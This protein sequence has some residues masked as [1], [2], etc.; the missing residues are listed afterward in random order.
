[1]RRR[2][3]HWLGGI[4]LLSLW[5]CNDRALQAPPDVPSSEATVF[6]DQDFSNQLDVLFVV[7]DSSS[8]Q[9]VQA[10]LAANFPTFIHVLQELPTGLPD[11]HIGVTTSS[12]GAGAFTA[13]VP[14][15][16]TPD[17]GNLV[18]QPRARAGTPECAAN[19]ITGPL[20]FI[21][22]LGQD[23]QRNF[24]GDTSQVFGC[25]AQVGADGCGF[26]QT[27]AAARGALGD[28][29]MGLPAPEGNSQFLREDA[30]LA[31]IWITNEDDC[32]VPPDS[33]LFDAHDDALGPFSYRCT[34]WGILCGG[35]RPPLTDSGPLA[36]CAS[37]DALATTAPRKSLVPVQFYVD[38][39]KR[40][41]AKPRQALLSLALPE[42]PAPARAFDR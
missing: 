14:G 34:E 33:L 23:S 27:I 42:Q 5:A 36:A 41:K 12:M 19:A 4:E 32:S 24:S 22:S 38:Y 11:V 10:N 26:E 35:H 1:M 39:F 40:L 18:Y 30:F 31:I 29:Q 15:C 37:D 3:R 9:T 2:R 7:D 20:H 25:I 16:G 8:M 17:A 6:F 13:A 28:P 21:E